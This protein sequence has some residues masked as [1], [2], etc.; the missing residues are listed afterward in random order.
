MI[1][2]IALFP[3]KASVAAG[4][5]DMLFVFILA[6]CGSV[7]L[8]VAVLLIYFCIRYRRRPG[9]VGNPPETHASHAL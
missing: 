8:L 7:G 3:E 6:V 9:E 2:E 4:Q 1:A 5:V